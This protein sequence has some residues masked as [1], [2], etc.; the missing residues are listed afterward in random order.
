MPSQGTCCVYIGL[1]VSE[2][3]GILHINGL[4][5]ERCNSIANALELHLSCTNPSICSHIWAAK[6]STLKCLH[7]AP[8][9]TQKLIM[10]GK[11]EGKLIKSMMVNW[12]F[13][14]WLMTG[15]DMLLMQIIL[16]FDRLVQERCNSIALAMELWGPDW[17][18]VL[19]HAKAFPHMPSLAEGNHRI[20]WL[21]WMV[22]TVFFQRIDRL[23][24]KPWH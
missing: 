14:I 1:L 24:Y 3:C 2:I 17:Y 20:Y 12:N 5:Q 8:P 13:L 7:D 9:V 4:V 22:Q 6:W 16:Y 11:D 10:W 23:C 15:C 18:H 19:P 21:W